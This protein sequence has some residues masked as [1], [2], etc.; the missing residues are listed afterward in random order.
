[1]SDP[2][3]VSL[4]SV[5][6]AAISEAIKFLFQQTGELLKH[7][8]EKGAKST[9]VTSRPQ[10]VELPPAFEGQLLDLPVNFDALSRLEPQ[11]LALYKD[12]SLYAADVLSTDGSPDLMRKV[13]TLR[14]ALELILRQ[15]LTL[16]G[17]HRPSAGLPLVGNIRADVI[18]GEAT[19]VDGAGLLSGPVSGEV[20]AGRVE[21][22]AKVT[23]T[24]WTR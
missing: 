12:L 4:A 22:G 8:R 19:G 21:Q 16:K 7:W 17:E 24:R 18:A 13:D 23:G 9:E 14:N 2:A 5:G 10:I 11:L 1:M 15:Q 6:S 20:Q 3:V